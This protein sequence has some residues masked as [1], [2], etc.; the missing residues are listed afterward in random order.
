[1]SPSFQ[2]TTEFQAGVEPLLET[3]ADELSFSYSLDD[4]PSK[5]GR[6]ISL[7]SRYARTAL[8]SA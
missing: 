7:R 3:L 6:S 8:F 5:R 2:L 4:S 1:M